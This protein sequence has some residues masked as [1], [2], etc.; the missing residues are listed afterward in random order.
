MGIDAAG[1]AIKVLDDGERVARLCFSADIPIVDNKFPNQ[2]DQKT[3]LIRLEEISYREVKRGFSVQRIHLYSLREAQN[4]VDERERRKQEKG[5]VANYLLAGVLACKVERVHAIV[6]ADGIPVF[7]VLAKP[8]DGQA[9]HAEIHFKGAI[10]KEDFLE[11]RL[12]LQ[13]VL[14]KLS[15]PEILDEAA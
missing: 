2:I 9:G 11:H 15:A 7:Q 14:G 3:K 13:Q 8:L 4:L 6:S 12:A 1:A 5:V 10:K